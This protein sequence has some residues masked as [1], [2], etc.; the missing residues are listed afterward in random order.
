MRRAARAEV[1]GAA[2]NAAP[3]LT[4]KAKRRREVAERKSLKA[5]LQTLKKTKCAPRPAQQS[6]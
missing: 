3:A 6:P 5:K 4:S 2:G 1:D